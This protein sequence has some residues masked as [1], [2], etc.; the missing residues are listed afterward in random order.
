MEENIIQTLVKDGEED[1][2]PGRATP[3]EILQEVREI[4]LNAK[5]IQQEKWEFI[6]KGQNWGQGGSPWVEN[7]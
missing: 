1:F 5:W 4:R 3:T 2:I 6:A 7:Y